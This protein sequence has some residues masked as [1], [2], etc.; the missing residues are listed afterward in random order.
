[1][2]YVDDLLIIS[3]RADAILHILENHF[4][5]RL[6][7]VGPPKRYLGATIEKINIDGMDTWS[8]S[9]REYLEKA[10]P[11]IEERFGTLRQNNKITTPLPKDYH[12]ELDN[13]EFLNDE[14]IEVYQSY[15]G[16]LRWGVELGRIDLCHACSLMARFA[17]APRTDHLTKLLGVFAY[18]KKH[19]QS[20][21]VFNHRTRDWK[22]IQWL[23]HDWK[24][25]YP[26][27]HEA[28]PT[29]APPP[30][31]KPVQIN[32]FCD[33]SH[34]TDLITRRSTTGIIIFLQGTPI[35]WYSKR[36]NTIES[37]T[38]GSEFVALKIVTEMVEGLRYRLRMMGVPINGPVNTFCDNDSV[39]K[40]VTNP[41]STLTKKHNAIA[42]HKVRESVAADVQRIAY[43]PGKYNVADL[44]TKILI[45]PLFK[46]CCGRIF[47]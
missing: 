6:K 21:I 18:V 40:N 20:R 28:I 17:A 8:M 13:S 47:Q 41:A 12:P 26:D 29:N 16:I 39:V 46:S 36:Q 34:A 23:Q 25:F 15:I 24:E 37:S 9:A 27:A 45:G 33:A 4:K 10:I 30:R 3:H 2:V 42:Y 44:L 35:I 14:Y 38:F 19:L 11:I 32:M 1:M 5:Y 43:E 31:G 22:N 7:D